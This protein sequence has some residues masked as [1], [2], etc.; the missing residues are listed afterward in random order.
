MTS[1]SA[2]ISVGWP[3]PTGLTAQKNK[4]GAGQSV[5]FSWNKSNPDD[6]PFLVDVSGGGF[7]NIYW[8]VMIGSNKTYLV[9]NNPTFTMGIP[10]GLCTVC[11]KVQAIYDLSDNSYEYTDLATSDW[12]NE[13]CIEGLPDTYC[14]KDKSIGNIVS[15]QNYGSANMRYSRAISIGGKN[16]FR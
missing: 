12:C 9:Y 13:V 2:S 7:Y 15:T 16:A 10:E 14:A 4:A 11:V 8:R 3:I 5:T 1:K 6:A